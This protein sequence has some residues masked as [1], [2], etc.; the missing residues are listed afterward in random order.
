[1]LHYERATALLTSNASLQLQY[2][3]VGATH[4]GISTSAAMC[5]NSEIVRLFD[6]KGLYLPLLT[7]S[8]SF[9]GHPN[10]LPLGGSMVEELFKCSVFRMVELLQLDGI[11]GAISVVLTGSGVADLNTAASTTLLSTYP[12]HFSTSTTPSIASTSLETGHTT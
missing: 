6:S 11:H 10:D 5:F 8:A 9:L 1:M 4:D 3:F 12:H 2:T 7:S